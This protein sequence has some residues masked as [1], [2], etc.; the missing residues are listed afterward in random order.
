MGAEMKH[1]CHA[2]PK[3]AAQ[4]LAN[5]A[6]KGDYRFDALFDYRNRAGHVVFWR[7]RMKHL[8]SHKKWIRPMTLTPDGYTLKGPA[9]ATDLPL[10]RLPE[11]LKQPDSNPVWI[12]E[13]EP[14]VEALHRLGLVATTSGGADS[15]D[16]ADWS[17]LA[18]QSVIIWP[19]ND[20]AGQR[21]AQS[22]AMILQ[23]L[24]CQ[25][26]ILTLAGLNLPAKGDVVDWC[27]AQP[28]ASA[29]DILAL[30]STPFQPMATAG[31]GKA[32]SGAGVGSGAGAAADAMPE[33]PDLQPF[34]TSLPPV[35]PFDATALL[36]DVLRDW[37]MDEAGRMQCPPDFIAVSAMVAI[38]T[39]IGTRCAIQPKALDDWLV[40]PN[41][42]GGL[43]GLPSVMKSPAIER[44][45]RP[46]QHL[47]ARAFD[48]YKA[49]A[50]AHEAKK[51]LMDAQTD[52]LSTRLK[53]AAKASASG[54]KDKGKA[55]DMAQIA[56]QLVQQRQQAASA[57][58]VRRYKTDDATI[59]KL[60]ELL[61]DNPGGILVKRDELVGLL[62]GWER[63]GHEGE[64]A[65][66]LEG[67]N[68]NGS[69][70]TD[71]I[72]RG[73]VSIPNLCLSVFGGIQPDKLTQYL[74]Q[75]A[76]QLG[77]DGMLQRFQMLVYPDI[78]PWCYTD[79]APDTLAYERVQAVFELLDEFDP[80]SWGAKRAD[81]SHKFPHLPFDAAAQRFYR[82]WVADWHQVRKKETED[83]PMLNQHLSKYGSLFPSL[84]LL[85][86]LVDCAATGQRGPVSA[87]AARRAGAWC[88]YLDAHAQRCYGLLL[89]D[90]MQSAK[91][92]ADKLQA[93][94][95]DDHF[96]ARDVRRKR[97]R[98]LSEEKDVHSALNCLEE[99]G[100]LWRYEIGGEGQGMGRRTAR[101]VI[102]PKAYKGDA[103]HQADRR[104][105]MQ[106]SSLEQVSGSG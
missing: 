13:G 5:R 67:W 10:Y 27:Q 106:N 49:E 20:P 4:H 60:G 103:M 80:A 78:G 26:S 73:E 47:I 29:A 18:G 85:L 99:E 24:A 36:P 89:D 63:E 43:V 19:D 16:S 61:R 31:T 72:A 74:Q 14:C 97:W 71:R 8:H 91:A 37:V 17:P 39:V 105:L 35:P 42:W 65:F 32:G 102:N 56:E 88:R 84:A 11:L 12:V 68:G 28:D 34:D 33:W 48:A 87:S 1:P 64:R 21:Y 57:P 55:D 94:K 66:Y 75:A 96:T 40:V 100:W 25:V 90:G 62:A 70:N 6:T 22:V 92:L 45:F 77:N 54:G 44:G 30:P 82:T 95:L 76:Y 41:L 38:S 79:R 101:Y 50:M 7:I 58:T 3:Q 51:V 69:F 23:G 9:C 98:D 83:D 53:A 104:G 59:E 2:T 52:A 86:H 15:A 46:L 81:A 93:G